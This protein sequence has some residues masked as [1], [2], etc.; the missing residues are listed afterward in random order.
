MKS[1]DLAAVCLIYRYF[2]QTNFEEVV[3]SKK[4][5]LRNN[6][7]FSILNSGQAI[8]ISDIQQHDIIF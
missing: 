2:S 8:A 5:S 6:E 7:L 3:Q 1:N 4:A